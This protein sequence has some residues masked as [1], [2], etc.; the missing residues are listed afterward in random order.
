MK[1]LFS[2][3]LLL[4]GLTGCKTLGH[5]T[6]EM[7]ELSNQFNSEEAQHIHEKGS[8]IIQG[9][10]FLRT[11]GGSV[12]TCAG[13]EVQLIPA[14]K[15]SKERLVHI[16]GAGNTG[17]ASVKKLTNTK[18][19][20]TDKGYLQNIRKARCDAQ[21][22]FKFSQLADGEYAV[23]ARVTWKVGRDFQGGALMEEVYLK[24]GQ[25]KELTM[26]KI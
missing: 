16:Y 15:Y 21:G 20:Q 6:V 17:Y 23:I 10:A 5:Q 24:D 8:N 26:T 14:S 12:V 4:M 13:F 11:N 22:N 1:K 2:M 19:V 9:Q 3:S 25:V 7:V 18:F